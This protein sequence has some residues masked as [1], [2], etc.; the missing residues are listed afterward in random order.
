[1][2]PRA[3]KAKVDAA[4]RYLSMDLE[5]RRAK[6][7]ELD[8]GPVPP[9]PDASG[10]ARDAAAALALDPA[11][12]LLLAEAWVCAGLRAPRAR[13]DL[14]REAAPIR[15]QEERE[16]IALQSVRSIVQTERNLPRREAILAAYADSLVTL[17]RPAR[18]VVDATRGA[19]EALDPA[20]RDALAPPVDDAREF[21]TATDE[22]WRELDRRV[23]RAAE[24]DPT[25]L[26]WSDRARS[27]VGAS[28][29]R[30]VP[31]ATWAALGTDWW[32]RVGLGDALR[33]VRDALGASSPHGRGVYTLVD[34]EAGGATLVGHPAPSAWDAAEVIGAGSLAASVARARGAWASHR[35]GVDRVTDAA[36]HAL[37]RRL[38]HERSFL[39]RVARLDS[40][41]RVRVQ[42]EALH[43][44]LA[45]LRWDAAMARFF[46]E[47]LER[48]PAI[49]ARFFEAVTSALGA[50]PPMSWA[51]HLVADAMEPGAPWGSRWGQRVEGARV[52]VTLRDTLRNQFNEDWHRNP[53]AGEW[54]AV[55]IDRM[56]ATGA[57]SWVERPEDLCPEA[58]ARRLAED[59]AAAR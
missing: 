56:R 9:R 51:A 6:L 44:E 50:S 43:A 30:E 57:A 5:A 15:L 4:A 2:T 11:S 26:R 53:R 36:F 34:P 39:Q 24:L 47:A 48:A 28:F 22:L 49:S 32:G 40:E 14:A 41:T 37:G 58:Q 25:S 17:Q 33:G 19:F 23:L 18:A 45:R 20:L 59:Y 3:M 27:L 8:P 38:S 31:P 21:L 29:V 13:Y 52:E 12:A 55:A 46:R 10:F 1:M 16:P 42:V 7:L 35:R 54:L